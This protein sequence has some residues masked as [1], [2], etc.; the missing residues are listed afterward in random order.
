M[1]EILV[2]NFMV[3]H[4]VVR[5]ER[6]DLWIADEAW[7]LDYYLHETP[8]EEA[9]IRLADRLRR[10]PADAGRR[11][12][13]ELPDRRLQRGDG[14]AHRRPPAVRDRAIFVGNPDDIV[15]ERLGPDLPMIREWTEEHFDFAGYVTGFDPAAFGDREA[16]RAELG[17]RPDE[18][19]CIVTVGGSGVGETCCAG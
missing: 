4:D 7:E 3:F 11:R 19:V 16:L 15:A 6:Y 2:A 10:L 18:Q 14:R 17:Y 8:S 1:D 9:P 5:E 13:R 12:A